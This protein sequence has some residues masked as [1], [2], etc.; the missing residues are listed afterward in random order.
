MNP[1]FSQDLPKLIDPEGKFDPEDYSFVIKEYIF[2]VEGFEH[3]PSI[4]LT[5]GSLV[6]L[7]TAVET[8]KKGVKPFR[9]YVSR[10]FLSNSKGNNYSAIRVKGTGDPT[11]GSPRFRRQ[12]D[13]DLIIDSIKV[14]RAGSDTIFVEDRLIS[15]SPVPGDW[16]YA[17]LGNYYAA[18]L[19]SLNFN[20]N[21]F[22]VTFEQREEPGTKTK[23][24]S[25]EP[26]PL[27]F[28]LV[29]NVF[30]GP[31]GSG[32]NAYI[33]G[34]PYTT[35]MFINGTIP[36]GQGTFTIKGADPYPPMQ[37]SLALQEKV[38]QN[39]LKNVVCLGDPPLGRPISL[40]N[41]RADHFNREIIMTSPGVDEMIG[42]MLRKSDN[43]LAERFFDDQSSFPDE[44]GFKVVDGSGLSRSNR[45]NSKGMVDYLRLLDTN[46]RNKLL[47]LLPGSGEGTLSNRFKGGKLVGRVVAKTGSMSGVRCLAGYIVDEGKPTH[48][49]CYMINTESTADAIELQKRMDNYLESLDL[50]H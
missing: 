19:W 33:H 24:I 15:N 18:G 38:R 32:D 27:H 17:D 10:I 39:G 22:K 7:V 3:N 35:R 12:H 30:A 43:L 36:P 31:E 50:V 4:S 29:N 40:T 20:D 14:W 1:C 25:T 34:A 45:L 48:V 42:Y 2:G 8:V 13:L 9:T 28:S 23:I 44:Y 16:K 11:F 37:L 5:P 41:S 6:K 46:V 26:E 21:R 47:D 49:F